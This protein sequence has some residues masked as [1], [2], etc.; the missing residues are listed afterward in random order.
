M[1]LPALLTAALA[2]VVLSACGS[3]SGASA[4]TSWVVQ[5]GYVS[6]AKALARD[7]A[8]SANAQRPATDAM[9]LSASIFPK[10]VGSG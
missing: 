8:Q 2:A 1:R 6:N 7:A 3:I 10:G 4:M 5:S 9:I